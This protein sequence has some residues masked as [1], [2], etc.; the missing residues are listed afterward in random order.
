MKIKLYV[1]IVILLSGFS[2]S[3]CKTSINNS[4]K[5]LTEK[6]MARV[7]KSYITLKDTMILIEISRD[8]ANKLGISNAYYDTLVASI[9]RG[10]KMIK[11]TLKEDNAVVSLVD[12]KNDTLQHIRKGDQRNVN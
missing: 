7:L 11:E 5:N 6:D 2:L 4:T 1:F 3:S 9:N 12:M 8:R 10:N